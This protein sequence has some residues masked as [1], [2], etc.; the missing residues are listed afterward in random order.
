M[1]S[2]KFFSA[3]CIAKSLIAGDLARVKQTARRHGWYVILSSSLSSS[4]VTVSSSM[5][6]S[7][8]TVSDPA[9]VV[10]LL[11]RYTME[12]RISQISLRCMYEMHQLAYFGGIVGHVL[13]SKRSL[14]LRGADRL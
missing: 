9:S 13:G 12:F 6:S 1:S 10:E 4:V 3:N 2:E 11:P 14:N 5:L 8:K 7:E